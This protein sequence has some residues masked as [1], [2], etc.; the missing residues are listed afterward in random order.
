MIIRIAW[1]IKGC[2]SKSSWTMS[3]QLVD[4]KHNYVARQAG[5]QE[6]KAENV[7]HESF[8]PRFCEGVVPL[9]TSCK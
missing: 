4:R 9:K 8:P 3:R 1:V 5:R 7:S 6:H 2:K